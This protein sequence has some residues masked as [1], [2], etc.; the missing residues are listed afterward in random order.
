MRK[1]AADKTIS[2]LNVVWPVP[3]ATPEQGVWATL[4]LTPQQ[5]KLL[6]YDA[7]P[8]APLR[9]LL[10]TH[11]FPLDEPVLSRTGSDGG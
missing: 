3:Q 9:T 2:L 6:V 8:D 1:V 5:A 4:T 11:P 10:A 7:A